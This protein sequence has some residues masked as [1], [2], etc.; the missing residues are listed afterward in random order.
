M[1]E[2]VSVVSAYEMGASGYSNKTAFEIAGIPTP[3]NHE[4]ASATDLI[5]EAVEE[6]VDNIQHSFV[7]D[8]EK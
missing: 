1:E 3:P 4:D 7:G 2:Q 6:I 5:S 8:G